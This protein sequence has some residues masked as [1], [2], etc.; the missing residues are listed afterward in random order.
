MA[1]YG[2]IYSVLLTTPA[3][4]AII[5][6]A[7]FPLVAP[8]NRPAPYIIVTHISTQANN[9]M[10]EASSNEYDYF[11]IACFA[12]TLSGAITLRDLVVAALDTN[13]V[14]GV[15]QDKR[16]DYEQTPNLYR[17]DADFLL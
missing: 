11:Q 7:V 10:S 5:G 13:E 14:G 4:A 8:T 3:I 16:D 1:K 17:S 6:D 2:T 12:S 15:L 9:T